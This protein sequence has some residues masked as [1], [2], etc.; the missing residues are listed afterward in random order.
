MKI[1]FIVLISW[2]QLSAKV[3]QAIPMQKQIDQQASRLA[4]K[5]ADLDVGQDAE[6]M[7]QTGAGFDEE[8]TSIPGNTVG[9]IWG[10]CKDAVYNYGK[11]CSDTVVEE[12]DAL[13]KVISDACLAVVMPII[14]L[15]N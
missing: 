13:F 15:P 4:Q 6:D 3:A 12:N 10:G 1:C 5:E 8:L 7:A 9:S 11:K 2:V 14:Y